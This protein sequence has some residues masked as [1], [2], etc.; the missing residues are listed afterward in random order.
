MNNSCFSGLIKEI[1]GREDNGHSWGGEESGLKWK[2]S[3]KTTQTVKYATA[4]YLS[5]SEQ[6]N[7]LS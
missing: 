1:S 2:S 6:I 3:L 4:D 5:F 7:S